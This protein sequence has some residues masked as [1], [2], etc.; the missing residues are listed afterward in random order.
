[1]AD[2]VREARGPDW[3]GLG[4]TA[5]Y[6]RLVAGLVRRG[7]ARGRHDRRGQQRGA[8]A[9]TAACSGFNSDA[10]GFRAGVEL[11]MGRSLDGA[12][13][14]VAGAGGAAHAV[15]FACLRAGARE[16]VVGNRTAGAATALVQ[17]FAGVGARRPV[18][19]R[20]GRSG[21]RRRA[22]VGGPGGQ[23]D[24]RRHARSR[25]DH[26]G[27]AAAAG[28]HRL[29][30]G[31]RPGRDAP[32]ARR[33]ARAAC[34]R[35]TARRCSS[36]RRPSPSSAGPAWAAWPTSCARPSRRCSPTPRPGPDR[37]PRDDRRGRPSG[38]RDRG[39]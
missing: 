22:R 25:G 14:V 36:P 30:P 31:L 5:P 26:R 7:R 28:R 8:A 21:L 4:V 12:A 23:R 15:V 17:R 29:R 10:P 19:G 35:R 2:A 38:G 34:G 27:R 1:M 11:A 37:A 20:P 24:D 13:V 33:L 6:K 39:R 32:A 9:T 16:V 3:L 18:R